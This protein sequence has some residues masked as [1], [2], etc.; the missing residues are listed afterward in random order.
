M[1]DDLLILYNWPLN[2]PLNTPC[3]LRRLSEAH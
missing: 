2:Y 3:P 1:K